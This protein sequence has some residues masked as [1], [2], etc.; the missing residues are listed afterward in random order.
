MLREQFDGVVIGIVYAYVQ[1]AEEFAGTETQAWNLKARVFLLLLLYVEMLVVGST[2]EK[3]DEQ[4]ETING[5]VSRRLNLFRCGHIKLLWDDLRCIGSHKPGMGHAPTQE[6]NE[7]ISP[8]C[9]R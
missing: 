7:K 8:R 1:A 3:S 5:C 9:S 4:E 6:E 2:W